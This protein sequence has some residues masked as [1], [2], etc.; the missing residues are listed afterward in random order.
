MNSDAPRVTRKLEKAVVGALLV[1][2]FAAF[3]LASLPLIE[4]GTEWAQ[5]PLGIAILL[6]IALDGG[7]VAAALGSL[8]RRSRGQRAHLETV[9][10]L[11]TIGVSL[12]VQIAHAHE[13]ER[14]WTPRTVII[15]AV[16]SAAPL[17][18]LMATHVALR[19][20][21]PEPTRAPRRRP[22]P[23]AATQPS[24]GRCE[25]PE[26]APPKK[27]VP[28]AK[29]ESATPAQLNAD[30]PLRAEGETDTDYAVRLVRDSG[31][32]QRQAA[33]AAGITRARVEGALKKVVLAA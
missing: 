33:A 22:A 30:I 24:T 2:A 4:V 28:L 20:V 31:V 18:T 16:L 5:L 21:A 25:A 8:V 13:I 10:L 17:T 15:A 9:L 19:A 14:V 1:V 11:L 32:S 6:P 26:A 12:G 27:P 3:L 29:P 7:A 23:Q